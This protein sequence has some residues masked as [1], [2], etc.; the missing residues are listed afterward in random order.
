[1]LALKFRE[2]GET[3]G[4]WA[5][6]QNK[7]WIKRGNAHRSEWCMCIQPRLKAQEYADL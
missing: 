2:N 1:M 6:K 7:K 4:S 3:W 5:G